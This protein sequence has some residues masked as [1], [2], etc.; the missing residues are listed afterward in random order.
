[1][2]T[3]SLTASPLFQGEWE[4]FFVFFFY[5]LYGKLTAALQS[6]SL[7]FEKGAKRACLGVVCVCVVSRKITACVC[8][9][10]FVFL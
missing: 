4:C 8:A 10:T 1:M 2:L 5:T 6:M 7:G 9:R 3:L